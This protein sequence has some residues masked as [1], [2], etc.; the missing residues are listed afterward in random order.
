MIEMIEASKSFKHQ[1]IFDNVNLTIN[2]GEIVG[3]VGHNGSGKTVL[4]KII[5]GLMPLTNGLVKVQGQ[6]VGKEID[7]PQ[8]I[9]VIIETPGFLPYLTGY[10]NLSQLASIKHTID[11]KRI[12]SVIA[13]VGLDPEDKK[14]V[15]H[16]SLGMKQRLGIAQ[17][18]ME[19]PEI[20]ILDE[21]FNGLDA[22]GVVAMR[23]LILSLKDKGTTILLASHHASDIEILCDH[24]YAF[25]HQ[26]LE[27]IR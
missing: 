13:E 10:Q 6:V 15:G 11:K 2:A 16:Y 23:K 12:K 18:I 25:N 24:V 3:V 4:F 9:G 20:L 1:T 8:N 26:Q 19:Y 17:A 27:F 21:P 14:T 5:C 7:I 22:E